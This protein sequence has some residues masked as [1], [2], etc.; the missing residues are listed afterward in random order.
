MTSS[1]AKTARPLLELFFGKQKR[2]NRPGSRDV[3][4]KGSGL[5]HTCCSDSQVA[6]QA[7]EQ[8]LPSPLLFFHRVSTPP[9]ATAN[10]HEARPR[11]APCCEIYSR[12][13]SLAQSPRLKLKSN[14]VLT[15]VSRACWCHESNASTPIGGVADSEVEMRVS[16]GL[17]K[18]DPTLPSRRSK[19]F[20]PPA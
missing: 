13:T 12:S 1:R 16:C 5:G 14:P 19:R 7:Y 4:S 9:V 3:T 8:Q 15:P 10:S 2:R 17:L 11:K 20:R 18:T 6:T